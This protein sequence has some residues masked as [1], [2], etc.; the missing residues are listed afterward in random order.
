MQSAQRTPRMEW[1]W[2][3]EWKKHIDNQ[4]KW[5]FLW[6]AINKIFVCSCVHTMLHCVLELAGAEIKL[7]FSVCV[8]VC[9]HNVG[10]T[11]NI[12][13]SLAPSHISHWHNTWWW[14]QQQW[15][16]QKAVKQNTQ[17]NMLRSILETIPFNPLGRC[18]CVLAHFRIYSNIFQ[19]TFCYLL[20][21]KI[22]GWDMRSSPAVQH[23]K[24][25]NHP[26]YTLKLASSWH[27]VF[28]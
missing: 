22:R 23:L 20:P 15:S 5:K 16:G 10:P 18:R 28:T 17:S 13:T 6:I 9:R 21:F 19:S 4:I 27:F 1:E 14:F 7:Q 3:K 2:E 12:Y 25:S 24:P 26:P 11:N 8:S